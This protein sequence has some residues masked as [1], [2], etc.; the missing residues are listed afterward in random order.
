MSG[1]PVISRDVLRRPMASASAVVLVSFL[2]TFSY[3]TIRHQGVLELVLSLPVMA[4]LA[5]VV[6][7]PSITLG[8]KLRG[9]LS[10]VALIAIAA[11]CLW[12][13]WNTRTS[14]GIDMLVGS[15]YSAT[16]LVLLRIVQRFDGRRRVTDGS[17]RP[18]Q[19]VR[20][21]G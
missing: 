19:G 4:I 17:D 7:C 8:R 21:I 6:F 5:I 3:D 14:N 20:P 12:S 9:T 1:I 13:G 16:A 18:A 11:A 2:S 15:F 10:H